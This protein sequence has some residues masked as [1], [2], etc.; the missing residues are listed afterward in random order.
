MKHFFSPYSIGTM[1][2][3][4][5]C[6]SCVETRKKT[7]EVLNSYSD[8]IISLDGS[9][10]L[11]LHE[12]EPLA[13]E[14][15][16][17]ELAF[18]DLVTL[19]GSLAENKKGSLNTNRDVWKN[20][21]VEYEFEGTAYYKCTITIPQD[22]EGKRIAFR[23]ERT[24]KTA[25]WLDDRLL[26]TNP[27]LSTAQVYELENIAPGEHELIVAVDN[28]VKAHPAGKSHMN[29]EATQTNWNGILGKIQLEATPKAFVSKVR[30][31]PDIQQKK[32]VLHLT[33]QNDLVETQKG[34]I[35][36]K[37]NS[38]NTDKNHSPKTTPIN[39]T[40]DG[41]S[42]TMEAVLELGND[43]LLWD[44]FDP[45][46]YRATISVTL[47]NG[48][49]QVLGHTFGM[50]S[51]VQ[52]GSQFVINGNTTF[53]RGKHDACVFPL[54]G[55]APM[56]VK[57]WVRVLK[58]AKVYG[59]NHYRFHTWCPPEA[60]L[61]AADLVGIYMQPELPSWGEL[62]AQERGV[63]FQDINAVAFGSENAG[64]GKVYDPKIQ[65]EAEKFFHKEAEHILDDY[66]NYASFVMFAIGNELS[67][68]VT[69][70]ERLVDG[71]RSYDKNRRLY[72]QG[73]NNKFWSPKKGVR[74]NYWTTVRTS[75]K[76]WENYDNNT[77]ISYS[78]VDQYNGGSVNQLR[79]TT[80]TNFAKAIAKVDVPVIGHE[81]G[82]YSYY[83][84]YNELEKYTGITK[85]WNLE[86]GRTLLK[87]KGMFDQWPDFFKA[88]G[89]WASILYCE[90]MESGIRTPGFGGFQLLDLQDFPGQGTA[91][92][93]PL[94]AFMES[95]G[96]IKPE[97]WREFCAPVVLLAEFD[98]YT[99]E[100]G[101]NFISD[102][103]VANYFKGDITGTISWSIEGVGNGSLTVEASQGGI[104]EAGQ[105]NIELPDLNQAKSTSLE[106]K[107]NK[108]EVVKSYPLWIYPKK[109]AIS[110]P[111]N[112]TVSK[113]LDSQT[114]AKIDAGGRVLLIPDHE[115]VK[116]NSVGPLFMSE[117]WSY[118]MF[119]NIATRKGVEP[120]PGTLGLLIDEK[121][122]ALSGFPT[123]FHTNWQWWSAVSNSRPIILDEAPEGYRPLVQTIDNMWRSFK[124]G[125]LF[126]FQVGK[127]KVLVSAIDLPLIE[128]TTEGIALY[129]SLLDYVASDA[130]NPET[131]ITKEELTQLLFD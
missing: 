118:R 23:M 84:D 42:K 89:T 125:T 100:A 11:T 111:E 26:G 29:E 57:E 7:S 16:L 110:M 52:N 4:L 122:P 127:G 34:Q 74:D 62:S 21:S 24:R 123:E 94:N 90:D 58:I 119:Y 17:E 116:D 65:T 33:I 60:A 83:P 75:G 76:K 102:I 44:E 64:E 115:E 120:S 37:V 22:W 47:E 117:F 27:G 106:L 39:F 97:K 19:P 82:Q 78:F 10:E 3:V 54:T 8:E 48:E 105:I 55:Y 28:I 91:L 59:I 61:A 38:F 36:I 92:V 93:G 2:M 96:T 80:R 67:G 126:E 50:R 112:V 73:S 128:D 69:V 108:S 46:L 9:W 130:F 99:L 98:Q 45:A 88:T 40:V 53:L 103:K 70:M 85:P 95:K 68:N 86:L 35:K 71:F 72:S 131:E 66:G 20:L 129:Q 30:V 109:K 49:K 14:P 113:T 31:F 79:P 15:K 41:A 1:M 6:F 87:E 77:R 5:T 107:L 12:E 13:S 124:L 43:M 81:T 51:F 32:A 56:D 25:V 63:S 101:N 121:H 104:S 114:L 18:G